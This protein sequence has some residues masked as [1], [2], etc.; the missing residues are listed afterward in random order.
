METQAVFSI[1]IAA[2]KADGVRTNAI[3]NAIP[4]N[5]AIH[6]R[7]L[8]RLLMAVIV[9]ALLQGS[10]YEDQPT[11]DDMPGDLRLRV[12]ASQSFLKR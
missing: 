10:Q 9:L 6:N 12:A 11:N 2:G 8:N 3:G 7:H 5:K 1:P 4:I